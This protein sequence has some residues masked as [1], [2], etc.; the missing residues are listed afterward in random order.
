LPPPQS[1][2]YTSI[3][4]FLLCLYRDIGISYC[5][6]L[7]HDTMLLEDAF[8]TG[9]SETPVCECGQDRETAEHFLLCCSKYQEARDEL[10]DTV[11]QVLESAKH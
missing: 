4:I 2:L 10:K 11:S 7:L 6:L 8:R 3:G 1:I 5:R 9:V